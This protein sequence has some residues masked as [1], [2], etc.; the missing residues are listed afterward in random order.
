MKN[1]FAAA[2]FVAALAAPAFAQD[3]SQA[4]KYIE[5]LRSDLKT[6]H[7]ALVT[8]ALD[9]NDD[10]GVLFWPIYREY[11]MKMSALND[12]RI[13]LIKDYATQ[14]GAI[15]DEGAKDLMKRAFKLHDKRM[16]LL[17][18]YAGKVD[19][20]LGGRI[21]GRWAQVENALLALVD[22]QVAAELPLL[23]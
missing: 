14:F 19:K 2:A 20:A 23:Q 13:A 15:T 11:D 17:Q 8:E 16:D 21:A 10:Q 6:K 1:M 3:A 12:E 4:E 9:L 7:T 5:L 22:V 18:Q